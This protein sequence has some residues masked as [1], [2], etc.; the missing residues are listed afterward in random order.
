M[1]VVS[2]KC[3]RCGAPLEYTPESGRFECAYCGGSYTENDLK[4]LQPATASEQTVS[5]EEVP[6]QE[7]SGDGEEVLLYTCPSC[8][9][10]IVT[11][12]TTAATTCLYCHSPV[13]LEGR[14]KGKFRPDR[15]IPFGIGRENAE[16]R[17]LDW[18]GKKRYVP[19]GYFNSAK[20]D[21]FMGVYYPYWVLDCHTR[22]TYSAKANRVR[23]WRTDDDEY[24]ETSVYHIS[25]EGDIVFNDLSR[26]AL[27]GDGRTLAD[28][29]MPFDLREAVPFSM[30][31]LSGFRAEMRNIET[32]EMDPVFQQ[33]IV[34]YSR[35]ILRRTVS[36]YDSVYDEQCGSVV[37][38]RQ[39]EYALFPVWAFTYQ[40]SDGRR[41]YYSMNAQTG[42]IAG[43]LPLDRLKLIRDSILSGLVVAAI[44]ILLMGGLLF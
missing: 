6:A 24:T 17:F 14:L 27:N 32:E 1:S 22:G 38:D 21:Y 43:E 4:E 34:E 25:R 40:G 20:N 18:V 44:V 19:K 26:C 8:G 42:K 16:A 5:V 39:F 41:Y 35:E 28:G 9:A 10:R 13:V 2:Y 7:G 30:P 31:Y 33:D 37:S 36:G 12:E 3:P 15:V 11:D 29:V 23:V